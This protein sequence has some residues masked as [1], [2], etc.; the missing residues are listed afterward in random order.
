[1]TASKLMAAAFA[2]VLYTSLAVGFII[3]AG[4]AWECFKIRGLM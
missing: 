2:A 1:M 3:G 4:I